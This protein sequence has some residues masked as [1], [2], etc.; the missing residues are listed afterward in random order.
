MKDRKM[1]IKPLES[2]G[3]APAFPPPGRPP[4]MPKA[5]PMTSPK[6]NQR[7][8]F[9]HIDRIADEAAGQFVS[10]IGAAALVAVL[11]ASLTEIDRVTRGSGRIVPQKQKQEVQHLEGGI[12]TDIF[13]REGERVT[14]G[15][16]LMRIENIFFRSELAQARIE[17]A[18]R[19]LKLIRLEAETSGAGAIQFPPE[20]AQALPQAVENETALFRRRQ[21]NLEEQISILV[22]QAR[23]KEIELSELRS[24]QPSLVRE[25]QISDERLAILRRLSASGAASTNEA[26]EAERLLQQVL[27]RLSDLAHDI[28]RGEA[29]LAEI[30]QRKRQTLSNFMAE[31]E[32]ERTQAAIELEKLTEGIAAM[33]DRI[34]RSEVVASIAGTINKLNVSTIGGVVKPGE[35][36]A[37]IVPA[38]TAIGIEMRLSPADRGNVWPGEKAIVKVSAY[39]Y[40]IHGGLPA[41]VI[42]ISPDALQD[43][44]ANPYFRVRLE[45]DGAGFGPE[46]PVLPG[47]VAEVD[48]IGERQSVLAALLRP[49]RRLKDNALRQ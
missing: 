15:Q 11:W 4:G 19:R 48:V 40:S 28:P 2:D 35:A 10:F 1:R 41:R 49:L 38:D 8:H 30:G 6:N 3:P 45:A 46:R 21:T 9:S 18:A 29:A 39:E 27:T 42:D 16:P 22:Q 25:R 32:K 26:L 20:L 37:E 43:E 7:L 5:Q 13:I 23:Q 17:L 24:R 36:L 31:A 47:M 12:V 33:Q 44:R 14:V 34:R